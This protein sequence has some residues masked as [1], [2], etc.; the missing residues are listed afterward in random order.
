MALM[1]TLALAMLTGVAAHGSGAWRDPKHA[2][3]GSYAGMRYIAEGPPHILKM[4]GSDDGETWWSIEGSCSGPKMT[5][6][7]FDFSSK[8]GPSDATATW[9]KDSNGKVTMLFGDGN[10]WE[11]MAPT[12]DSNLVPAPAALR[13]EV[14]PASTTS[15]TPLLMMGVAVLAA[16]AGF[17]LGKAQRDTQLFTQME[18]P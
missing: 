11:L 6:M 13:A 7:H 3:E 2:V 1:I 4:V 16:A 10:A 12:F 8:G 14:A 17:T 5:T 9:N 15:S 18:E